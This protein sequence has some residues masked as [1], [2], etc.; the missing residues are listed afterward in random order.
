MG[1]TKLAPQK[2]YR[3]AVGAYI[4]G[5]G[6]GYAM[7]RNVLRVIDAK[8]GEKVATQMMDY[9]A[10]RKTISPRLKGRIKETPW[11]TRIHMLRDEQ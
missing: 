11:R 4:A 9:I 7:L 5:G 10:A 2:L 1:G 6:D 8:G 3:V